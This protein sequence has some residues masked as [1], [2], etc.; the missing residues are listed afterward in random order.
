MFH[1]Y[2]YNECSVA[3]IV[4][5]SFVNLSGSAER[6][7]T[8]VQPGHQKTIAISSEAGVTTRAVSDDTRFQW[9][10]RTLSAAA[11]EFTHVYACNCDSANEN[12]LEEW[13]GDVSR[14]LPD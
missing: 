13:P 7:E 12:C 8:T 9:S 11:P 5:S 3:I 10:E 1:F 4:V 2:A 6:A 14:Q